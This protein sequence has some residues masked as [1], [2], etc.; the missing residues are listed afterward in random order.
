MR[1]LHLL[2]H[3]DEVGNGIVNVAVD[4]AC[5]QATS[6]HKVCVCASGGAYETLL[7]RC[8]VE[9]YEL[10]QDRRPATLFK[11][12]R[13]LRQTIRKV[14]PDIVHAHMMTGA[15]L[16]K[17]SVGLPQYRL[18]T[19]VHNEFQRAAI[20]MG[21]GDR[22]IA[23]SDAVADA[24]RRRGIP[25]KKLRTVRNGTIGSPRHKPLT[26]YAA[27]D[28]QAPAIVT[29][30]GM[31]RR[32]GVAE[33]LEAFG[34]VAAVSKA[35]LYLVGDGHD[36]RIFEA[37]AKGSPYTSRIHFE[38]FQKFP[39][40]YLLAA[41]IFVL[42]SHRE[43]FGLVLTEAREAGCAIVASNVDGIP[44][45]LDGGEAGLLV[46]ARNARALQESLIALLKDPERRNAFRLKA[47]ANLE[48]FSVAH[49]SGEIELVYQ[50]LLEER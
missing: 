35:H 17:F 29:V 3:I 13:A 32:K 5:V 20:L 45:A 50:E 33:L 12:L 27:A 38:G 1:I 15:L 4:L 49:V 30:A 22:V 28:L 25:R 47:R 42:A 7:K 34:G 23:V 8:G 10:E 24:M 21:V 6:G 18:V 44:E 14:K 16:A 48:R 11:A 37:Q 36:R 43:P 31:Y 39:Q 9:F 26:S 41:D 19:H 40:P 2:N 46:P